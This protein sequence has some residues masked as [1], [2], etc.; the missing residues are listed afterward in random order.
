MN[1]ISWLRKQNKREDPIGDLSRDMIDAKFKFNPESPGNA[2]EQLKSSIHFSSASVVSGALGA[3]D[4]AWAE[5]N[6]SE[7][8]V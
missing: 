8:K 4:E 7:R 6:K 5:F 2:Y 1:F 3:L